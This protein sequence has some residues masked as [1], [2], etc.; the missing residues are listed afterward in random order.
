MP[1]PFARTVM[2]FAPP[3]FVS[4]DAGAAE[5]EAKHAEMQRELERVRDL[6]EGW[7]GL[8]EAERVRHRAE[9]LR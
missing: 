3:I 5:L 2:L 6:A 4:A 7:F 9:F 1:K 8:S